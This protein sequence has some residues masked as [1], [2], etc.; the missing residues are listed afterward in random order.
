MTGAFSL[1]VHALVYLSH[2]QESLSSEELSRN[3]CTNAARVR[4]IVALLGKAGLVRAREGAG[5]GYVLCESPG[6]VTL[7]RVARA[8]DVRLVEARWHSGGED[9]DC[10]VA[11]GMAAVMDGLYE[12]LNRCCLERLEAVTLQDIERQIFGRGEKETKRKTP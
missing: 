9:M 12:D 5:G 10:L 11:S 8:V 2:R 7:A 4:K 3:I 1:A 6:N